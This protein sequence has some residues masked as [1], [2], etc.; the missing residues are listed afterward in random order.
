M[1]ELGQSWWEDYNDNILRA[2]GSGWGGDE[3]LL[4]QEMREL[5][6]DVDTAF[7]VTGAN[8]PG[9][10][11]PYKDGDGPD[12]EAY[13]RTSN[14]EKFLIVVARVQAWTQVLLD[15]G[16]AEETSQIEWALPPMEAAGSDAILTPFA[17]GAVALVLTTHAPMDNDHPFN[18]TISAGDPAVRLTS[19]PD[20][21]CDGC[22]SGSALLLEDLDMSVLSVVD[23]SLDVDV[24]DNYYW[25]RTSFNVKGR[26]THN[27]LKRTAFTA[28]PWPSKWAARPVK[29]LPNLSRS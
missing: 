23:G 18:V 26:A 25:V 8:T 14:P 24:A 22:D 20:C 19:L 21:A 7:A 15:R 4:S 28:A 29:P 1:T 10:P 5:L 17:D 11:N 2:R 27:G 9:W 13:E 6:D 16:W 12:K 3:P